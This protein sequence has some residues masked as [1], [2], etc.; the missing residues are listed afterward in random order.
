[1]VLAVSETNSFKKYGGFEGLVRVLEA[2]GYEMVDMIGN[3]MVIF[4][5]TT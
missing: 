2:S 4:Q 3:V 1:M 5:R